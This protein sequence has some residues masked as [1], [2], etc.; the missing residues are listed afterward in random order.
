MLMFISLN[1]ALHYLSNEL[2]HPYSCLQSRLFSKILFIQKLCPS[3]Y[4]YTCTNILTK[5]L[6]PTNKK[7]SD[8]NIGSYA[9]RQHQKVGDEL[10]TSNF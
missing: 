8:R 3:W 10:I 7:Y 2:S 9:V 5:C 1:R 4:M 6:F